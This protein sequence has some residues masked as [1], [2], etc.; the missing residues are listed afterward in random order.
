MCD[1][2]RQQVTG[3]MGKMWLQNNKVKMGG[4]VCCGTENSYSIQQT[5]NVPSLMMRGQLSHH[6]EAVTTIFSGGGSKMWTTLVLWVA[7]ETVE[8]KSESIH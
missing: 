5:V 2:N 1:E 3:K 7:L 4:G 8:T 6:V